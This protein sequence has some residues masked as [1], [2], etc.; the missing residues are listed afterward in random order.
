[1]LTTITAMQMKKTISPMRNFDP[2]KVARYEKDCWVA[3]Y[4]RRWFTL[5]RL[6]IGLIR[7]TYGLALFQAIRAAIP[8]TRAQLAFA[9]QANDVPQAIEFMR[10]FFVQVKAIHHEDFD[11][12]DAARAE[13][14]WWVVHRKFFGHS[15]RSEVT[16]A[17]AC[18]YASAYNLPPSTVWEAAQYR[19]QAM[20]YSDAWVESAR[21][22]DSPLLAKE[23]AALIKSYT[24]LKT[25][26]S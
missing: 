21:D 25:A 15:D 7:S 9:P 23:E 3:Y 17:V 19:A 20:V 12:V 2:I 5:L 10:Q 8:A 6:L 1:M 4:Q 16:E 13:V 24:A 26:V 18:A 14:S 11:P 22:P